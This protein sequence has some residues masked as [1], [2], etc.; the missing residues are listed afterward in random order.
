MADI[1]RLGFVGLGLMGGGMARIL[2]KAGKVLTVFDIDPAKMN[3]LKTLGAQLAASPK[4][5]GA[6]SNVVLSSVPDS[7][8]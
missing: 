3:S 2:L 6:K 5:V 4:E 1:N 8:W 7:R